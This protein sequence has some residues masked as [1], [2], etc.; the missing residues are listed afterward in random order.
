MT[1]YYVGG[2]KPITLND[3]YPIDVK[4]IDCPSP[5]L[6]NSPRVICI[7]DIDGNFRF[8]KNGII[9][10]NIGQLYNSVSY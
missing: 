10:Q 7:V 8:E 6:F 5:D 9:R 4:T 3:I 1:V 2:C